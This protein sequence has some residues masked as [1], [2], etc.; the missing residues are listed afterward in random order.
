M[1]ALDPAASPR[2]CRS[3][4]PVAVLFIVIAAALSAALAG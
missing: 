3:H 1:T 2:S 4:W